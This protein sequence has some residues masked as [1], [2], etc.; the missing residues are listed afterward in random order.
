MSDKIVDLPSSSAQLANSPTRKVV[1]LVSSRPGT[2]RA[3]HGCPPTGG[4][5]LLR[6]WTSQAILSLGALVC[7][8][9]PFLVIGYQFSSVT[10]HQNDSSGPK[11]INLGSGSTIEMNSNTELRIWRQGATLRVALLRGEA[12]FDIHG[13]WSGHITVFAGKVA[14]QDLG[15]H[16]SARFDTDGRVTV[17]LALGKVSVTGPQIRNITLGPNQ[18]VTVVG[19]RPPG[20]EPQIRSISSEEI[21]AEWSW[22]DMELG[23]QCA[24]TI[25]VI[26]DKFNRYG[27]DKIV[28]MGSVASQAIAGGVH[29]DDLE[30]FVAAVPTLVPG[31]KIEKSDRG[32]HKV[33]TLSSTQPLPL[34]TASAKPC[35]ESVH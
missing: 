5:H 23:F 11:H 1:R 16:F 35:Q 10:L 29:L 33:Y 18:Q 17:T 15:T 30:G 25:G 9:I 22:H 8:S 32:D 3:S 27:R 20:L 14:I 24:Q 6:R 28:V 4:A 31:V 26:A 2:H 21:R 13:I 19:S 12:I 7:A 34:V